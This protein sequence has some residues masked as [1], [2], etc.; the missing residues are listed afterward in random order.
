MDCKPVAPLNMQTA[1]PLRV[2]TS[3]TRRGSAVDPARLQPGT[4]YHPARGGGRRDRGRCAAP[5]GGA[6]GLRVG[7]PLTRLHHVDPGPAGTL[8]PAVGVRD[9]P[10]RG[11]P[12]PRPGSRPGD[13]RELPRR[14]GGHEINRVAGMDAERAQAFRAGWI[15]GRPRTDLPQA[16]TSPSS[17]TSAHPTRPSAGGGPGAHRRLAKPWSAGRSPVWRVGPNRAAGCPLT[18]PRAAVLHAGILVGQWLGGQ[19]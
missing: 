12:R 13:G 6:T 11:R 5:P 4:H 3:A 14:A 16:S 17:V 9:R 2:L 7:P 15:T 1:A 10:P 18:P 8:D 19:S